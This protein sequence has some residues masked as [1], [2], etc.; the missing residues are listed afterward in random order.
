MELKSF[1]E[2]QTRLSEVETRIRALVGEISAMRA[3]LTA[4]QGRFDEAVLE[5]S[6]PEEMQLEI[7]SLERK[8][9]LKQR[10]YAA[11]EAATSGKARTGKVYEAAQAVWQEGA[12]LITKDLREEWDA[13][14][15]ELEKAKAQYLAAVTTLGEIKRRAEGLTAKLSYGLE[16]FLPRVGAP[17]LATGIYE[18]KYSGPIFMDVNAI[19]KAYQRGGE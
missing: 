16:R 13:E 11:L 19:K 9:D 5:G 14:L 15:V 4:K 7:E 2:F 17:R 6:D 10:E 8:I 1:T 18:E 3:D 12:D